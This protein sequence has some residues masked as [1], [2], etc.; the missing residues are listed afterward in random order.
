MEHLLLLVTTW[1]YLK[2][3]PHD[4]NTSN[5]SYLKLLFYYS[6][7]NF[8]TQLDAE[9]LNYSENQILSNRCFSPNL[10]G[11]SEIF[12]TV[13]LHDNACARFS[14]M[15]HMQEGTSKVPASSCTLISVSLIVGQSL[16]A[17]L[18]SA[19][20]RP[21]FKL[22]SKMKL[23]AIIRWNLIHIRNLIKFTQLRWRKNLELFLRW[24]SKLYYCISVSMQIC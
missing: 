17:N 11:R 5:Y 22:F 21:A 8:E 7:I 13:Y 16:C 2:F 20:M 9:K 10:Y 3:C 12:I 18:L 4:H 1:T 24:R 19:N 6:N 14:S 15:Q 23:S